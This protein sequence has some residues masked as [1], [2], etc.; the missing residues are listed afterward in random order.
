[1]GG[2]FHEAMFPTP[3]ENSKEFGYLGAMGENNVGGAGSDV[4]PQR[5]GIE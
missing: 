3:S 5:E 2:H 4:E 1:M